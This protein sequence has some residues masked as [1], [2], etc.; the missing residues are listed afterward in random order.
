MRKISVRFEPHF[1][2]NPLFTVLSTTDGATATLEN[3]VDIKQL[4]RYDRTDK[5]NSHISDI[6]R[7]KPDISCKIKPQIYDGSD[8]L[9]EYL[10]QFNLLAKLND[11]D[12]KIKALLLASSLSGSARAIL[13]EITDG[14]RHDFECLVNAM[15]SRFGSIN[16]SEVYRADLQT[17]V[18]LKNETLPELAQAIKKLTR[19]AYPD[20]TPPTERGRGIESTATSLEHLIRYDRTDKN[21]SHISDIR[22]SKPDISCKIKPQIY[23]GS[24]DLEEYLTQFNLLAKLN[25]WDPK[26]KALLL[27]SSLSGSARAILNEITDGERHDFEC[28]VNAMK[29][30][31]GSI[32]RSEVYRADLQTRVRLKNETL[33]ELAQ[34]IKKLTRRAYPDP[35]PPTERGW[36]NFN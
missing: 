30:R 24:D 5:N 34:A 32:N 16:R 3:I 1:K 27:A 23:D 2:N 26:I 15:K 35:T 9:E 6:R 17:R 11:W 31:F 25:D 22:R 18:R 13:N 19:R 14:E 28:L 20:P 8:D 36:T 12:P 21:N 4:Y 7:S 10:T 29:S 33:P